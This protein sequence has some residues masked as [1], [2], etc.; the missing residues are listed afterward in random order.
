MLF[1]QWKMYTCFPEMALWISSLS[2]KARILLLLLCS[3]ASSTALFS[4]A[5]LPE[6]IHIVQYLSSYSFLPC[7]FKTKLHKKVVYVQIILFFTSGF[8]SMISTWASIS[9]T[10]HNG[11][12]Q[13]HQQ[14]SSCQTRWQGLN[15]FLSSIQQS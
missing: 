13:G 2:A 9:T 11:F 6:S 4:L 14:P 1:L 15:Q 8:S 3:S 10:S 7:C 12:S 5:F